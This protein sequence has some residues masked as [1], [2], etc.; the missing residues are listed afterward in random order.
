MGL[1]KYENHKKTIVLSFLVI[2]F[3]IRSDSHL[4][5]HVFHYFKID[6][7]SFLI[8]MLNFRRAVWSEGMVFSWTAH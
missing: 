5:L 8:P 3:L 2:V 7:G 1:Q 4:G 6:Y